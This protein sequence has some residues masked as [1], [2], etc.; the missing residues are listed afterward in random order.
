MPKLMNDD[1]QQMKATGGAFQFSAVRP[2]KLGAT[3][4]TLVTVIIDVTGSVSPFADD[5]L[6]MLKTVVGACKKSPRSDNLMLR[7]LTF[8]EQTY[9]IHGFKLLADINPDDYDSFDPEGTTAVFDAT[10]DGVSGT[11][12]YAKT[13]TDQD[14]DVNGAVYIITDGL[15][16]ASRYYKKTTPKK[17]A[18]YLQSIVMGEGEEIE[19]LITVLIGLHDPNIT[20]DSWAKEANRALTEFQVEANL[21]QFVDAGDATPQRL[22]KLASFVSQSISSQSQNLGSG[23]ASQPLNF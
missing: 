23:Q 13:L 15:D 11:C 5:L 17:I 22:A 9:E 16:N 19:S 7:V 18:D 8:N 1:M 6:K 14:F 10:L 4:Y 21:T 3:E 20:G 2:E 12:T